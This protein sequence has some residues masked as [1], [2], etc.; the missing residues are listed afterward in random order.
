M[1]KLRK[2]KINESVKILELYN[3]IIDTAN[4]EFDPKW[5]DEYINLGFIEDSILK[6]ELYVYK[7]DERIISSVVVNND[8]GKRYND[9]NWI[10]DAKPDEIVV[11]HTFA[12]NPSCRGRGISKEIFNIIKEQSLKKHK[13]TI[14]V[15][16]ING[17]NGAEIVFKHLGFKHV[18]TVEEFY[19]AVGL[20]TFHLYEHVLK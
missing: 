1:I 9:A 6:E 15:D 4:D 13:K 7:V 5:N 20:E 19:D 10:V 17:N 11:I 14:R 3:N 18:D 16:V 8:F 2:A 12:V